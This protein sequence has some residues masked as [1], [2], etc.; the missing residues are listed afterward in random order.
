[1]NENPLVTV[2]ILSFNRKDELRNTLTKVYEQD[3]KNIEVIVVDN[4]SS[5]G[6]PEMVEKEF[7]GVKLI[8]LEKN[9]GIAGWNEGF[10][11]ARG[12]YVLVLDD[13]SYPDKKTIEKGLHTLISKESVAIV[14]FNIINLERN[15]SQTVFYEKPLLDFVGCGAIIKK[16]IFFNVGGFDHALFIY[17]HELDFSIRVLNAGFEIEY[18]N[19]AIIYHRSFSTS[20]FHPIN[21]DFRFYHQTISYI[22]ILRKYLS[23]IKYY[24]VLIKLIINR[25]IIA[26]YFGRTKEYLSIVKYLLFKSNRS[27][28]N[29]KIKIRRDILKLYDF[30]VAILDRTYFANLLENHS[31]M[32]FPFLILSTIFLPIEQK[33]LYIK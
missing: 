25:L 24:K 7:P 11:M 23:K 2:N 9:I 14:A 32:Q 21:N 16:N 15:L 3:Y 17:V 13:D 18:I 29:D 5:D 4:A 31:K 22:K 30:N 28:S 33:N 20:K 10:R 12:E 1:M 26:I 8:K 19:D 27:S 6:S